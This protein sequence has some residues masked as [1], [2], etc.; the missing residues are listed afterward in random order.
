ML[1]TRDTVKEYV[2]YKI[3]NGE[4]TSVFYDKWCEDGPLSD[5]INKRAIYDARVQDS[6]VI[7]DMIDGDIWKWPVEC[8]RVKFSTSH[9]WKTMKEDL[10]VVHWRHVVWYSQLIPRHAFI[11]WLEVQRKLLTQDRME[12]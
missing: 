10:P 11:L 6:V 2:W 1:K 3:G 12:K 9:A 4:N 7:T 8:Q 5:F